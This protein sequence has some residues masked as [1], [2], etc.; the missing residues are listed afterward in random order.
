MMSKLFHQNLLLNFCRR[1][2]L[3]IIYTLFIQGNGV[4]AVYNGNN[5][6]FVNSH[7]KANVLQKSTK[8]DEGIVI[9]P[10]GTGYMVKS[11]KN[12]FFPE[13]KPENF[14]DK[15]CYF[16][17]EVL[18]KGIKPTRIMPFDISSKEPPKG[19]YG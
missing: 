8:L 14:C 13:Y 1:F 17:D 11:W 4:K 12:I 18:G 19:L 10:A 3:N 7:C 2:I 15:P 6:S 5:Y 16:K 9:C